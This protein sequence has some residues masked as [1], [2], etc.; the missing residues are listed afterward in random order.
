MQLSLNSPVLQTL[1]RTIQQRRAVV[2]GD[3][4]MKYTGASAFGGMEPVAHIDDAIIEPLARLTHISPS[5]ASLIRRM[6]IELER[7]VIRF[8][9]KPAIDSMIASGKSPFHGWAGD[10]VHGSTWWYAG[11]GDFSENA[12]SP[13]YVDH[14]RYRNWQ[15]FCDRSAFDGWRRRSSLTGDF[16]YGLASRGDYLGE[17]LIEDLAFVCNQLTAHHQQTINATRR[18]K[19]SSF[20]SGVQLADPGSHWPQWTCSQFEAN[21][22]AEWGASAIGTITGALLLG[23]FF[24]ADF[25]GAIQAFYRR[26]STIAGRYAAQAYGAYLEPE[27]TVNAAAA[28]SAGLELDAEYIVSGIAVGAGAEIERY[29]PP[30]FASHPALPGAAYLHSYQLGSGETKFG[31][32]PAV[33]IPIMD[34]SGLIDY[35]ATALG[36][37]GCPYPQTWVDGDGVPRAIS[38]RWLSAYF[39]VDYDPVEV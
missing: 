25:S 26:T 3:S 11:G 37:P 17:W 35:P 12:A 13:W 15:D 9:D 8:V 39:V 19:G 36:Y 30:I 16:E 21:M 38:I 18:R 33:P 10:P 23:S 7:L 32:S 14:F 29:N 34:L 31:V 1:W 22:Q 20:S 28:A 5:S 27:M 4:V 6:Q 2:R 24:E